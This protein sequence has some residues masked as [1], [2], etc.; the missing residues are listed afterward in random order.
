MMKERII[1]SIN[2][3]LWGCNRVVHIRVAC[4][5]KL[6]GPSRYCHSS[7]VLW[8][9]VCFS[10]ESWIS[11][12]SKNGKLKT[13]RM[14]CACTSLFLWPSLEVVLQ[15]HRYKNIKMTGFCNHSA[16]KTQV[17]QVMPLPFRQTA[18]STISFNQI[19]I[20]AKIFT[21]LYLWGDK[22]DEIKML[23]NVVQCNLLLVYVDVLLELVVH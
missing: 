20:N 3:W 7:T 14:R 13:L 21:V 2:W 5:V 1:S 23:L 6:V 9:A 10:V 4:L 17:P 12:Y 18:C 22:L 11:K 15:F 8:Y 16:H 19:L